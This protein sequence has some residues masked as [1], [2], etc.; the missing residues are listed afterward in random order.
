MYRDG[1][2]FSKQPVPQISSSNSADEPPYI[3]SA[4]EYIH[5][6]NATYIFAVVEYFT[7]ANTRVTRMS[8]IVN[9]M[10]IL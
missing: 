10:N 9:N 2:F 4:V 5:V 3:L 6:I 8:S 1:V 7:L